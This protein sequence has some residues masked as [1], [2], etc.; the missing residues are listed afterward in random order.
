V[1]LLKE[2][3]KALEKR[4]FHVQVC[5]DAAQSRQQA[6]EIIGQSSAGF[7]GSVTLDD[8][9]L[10][11]ILKSRGND[12]AW[13]WKV[14]AEQT[15]AERD[16]ALKKEIYLTSANAICADG[17]MINIDGF[18]NRV[19]GTFYGPEKVI[20]I[21]GRNKIVDG[22]LEDAIERAKRDACVPNA[23]RLKRNTPCAVTG[24]CTDCQSPDRMCHVTVILEGPS[25][26]VKAF[27]VLLVDEDL[28]Y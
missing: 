13:H 4:G 20:L 9:G 18:G 7:G 17:K 3:A 19:A 5:T 16:A 10:Y 11:D 22:S 23:K 28:G 1:N 14:P 25:T 26:H 27:Y 2:T 8:L 24:Q 12:V 15:L 21:A 6:L